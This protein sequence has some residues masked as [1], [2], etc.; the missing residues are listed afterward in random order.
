MFKIFWGYMAFKKS[1]YINQRRNF[2][3]KILGSGV[4]VTAAY[5]TTS[6]YNNLYANQNKK[7]DQL[8]ITVNPV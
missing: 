2:I 5:F 7:K 4:A 8:S 1:T 3:K 6:A